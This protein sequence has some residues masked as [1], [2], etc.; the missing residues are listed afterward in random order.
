MKKKKKHEQEAKK[1]GFDEESAYRFEQ[2]LAGFEKEQSDDDILAAIKSRQAKAEK[3]I[4]AGAYVSEEPAKARPRKSK[5]RKGL[6][7][8]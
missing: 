1:M 5:V 8:R 2:D 6:R 3:A 4:S 7:G